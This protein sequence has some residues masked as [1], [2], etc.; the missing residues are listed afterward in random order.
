MTDTFIIT[1]LDSGLQFKCKSTESVL[2]AMDRQGV[3]SIPVGCRGGG[4][5]IC[6]VRITGGTFETGKMSKLH[7]PFEERSEGFGL[8]CRIYPRSDLLFE[9]K[10]SQLAIARI[11]R[12]NQ[13]T[14]SLIEARR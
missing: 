11:G 5:G 7:V 1:D 9:Y 3:K 14:Q 2:A 6:R 8:S 13:K 10:P 4:C 12:L